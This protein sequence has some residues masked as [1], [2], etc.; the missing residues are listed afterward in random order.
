MTAFDY[1]DARTTAEELIKD[2]GQAGTLTQT[3][4]SGLSYDPTQTTTDHAI[5][6]VVLAY[7]ESEIDGSLIEVTDKK[8]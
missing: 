4:N 8:V 2:F 6:L 7:D 5:T 1:V 3:V